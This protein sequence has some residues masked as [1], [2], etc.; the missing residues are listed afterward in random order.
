M[1]SVRENREGGQERVWG[2]RGESVR[3]DRGECEGG[4]GRV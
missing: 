2:R 1:D 4:Q 3:E